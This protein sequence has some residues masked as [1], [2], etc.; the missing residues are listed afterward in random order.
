M[1][2]D[3]F[4]K[5]VNPLV[6]ALAAAHDAGVTHRDFKPGSVMISGDGRVKVLDF[7][8]AKIAAETG[9]IEA[10]D[11]YLRG[12]QFFYEGTRK[13]I[14]LARG[15][16]SR[17]A[18][19]DPSYALAYAGLANC[20][21]YLF[22]YFDNTPAN[23]NEAIDASHKAVELGDIHA[24]AHEARG[25]ALSLDQRY[26][27]AGREFETALQLN[28]RLFEAHYSYARVCREQGGLRRP[29]L[30]SRRPSVRSS[31]IRTIPECCT[32]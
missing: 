7:G 22:M 32:T 30:F 27:E 20:H 3:S 28:P 5:I 15:M 6:E 25:L 12:R 1:P 14:E 26:E 11:F 2:I 21:S 13:G 16:Y 8:I 18:R 29:F 17:A 23:K 31:S 4:W 24:D 19:R 9:D 10:Y